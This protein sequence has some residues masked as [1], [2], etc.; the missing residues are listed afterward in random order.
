MTGKFAQ[1]LFLSL[2][3]IAFLAVSAF[4]ASLTEKQKLENR[5]PNYKTFPKAK[6]AGGEYYFGEQGPVNFETTYETGMTRGVVSSRP[7]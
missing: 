3:I 5:F 6:L 7:P 2:F 4:G 1:K